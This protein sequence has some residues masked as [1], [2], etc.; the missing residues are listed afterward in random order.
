M[1]LNATDFITSNY[2]RAED[3]A[4]DVLIEANIVSARAHEFEGGETKLVLY[5]DYQSKGVV[6]NQT[7]LKATIAA[8]G[9]NPDNWI[10]RTIIIR[11]GVT[12][13]A[14]KDVPGI[15]IE[16]VRAERIASAAPRAL[17][18][19][20]RGSIDIRSGKGAWDDPP[21]PDHYDGPSD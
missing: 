10:G 19:P 1:S 21:P 3:I 9:P 7:R 2:L 4:P 14:G 6:L 16:P 15:V 13:F 11:R 8:F 17:E 12:M 20:R 5:V 18:E